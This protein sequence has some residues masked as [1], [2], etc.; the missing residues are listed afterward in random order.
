MKESMNTTLESNLLIL[1]VPDINQTSDYYTKFL[2]FK[3][4]KYLQSQQ[5]YICLYRDNVEIILIQSK[6]QKIAPIRIVHGYGYDGYFTA[7][8][9]KPMYEE[10]VAKNVKIVKPLGKTDYG[11][12]E[13]VLEDCNEVR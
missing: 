10:L 1:P 4:V 8:N 6:L 9:I 3:A 7:K 13:F 11:N 5:P 12:I 2:R